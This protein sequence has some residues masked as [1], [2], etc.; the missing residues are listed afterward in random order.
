MGGEERVIRQ[1][2]TTTFTEAKNGNETMDSNDDYQCACQ[3]EGDQTGGEEDS[4]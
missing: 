1:R 2:D 3:W 4:C